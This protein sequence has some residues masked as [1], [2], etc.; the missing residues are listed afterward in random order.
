MLT[1]EDEQNQLA[2]LRQQYREARKNGN[3]T[4]MD[5]IAKMAERVKNPPAKYFSEQVKTALF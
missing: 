3:Q 4:K 1:F 5:L 2:K